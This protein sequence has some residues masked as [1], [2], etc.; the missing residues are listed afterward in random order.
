MSTDTMNTIAAPP[1]SGDTP[2]AKIAPTEQQA[3]QAGVPKKIVNAQ[4]VC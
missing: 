1:P 4:T 2:V 3:S